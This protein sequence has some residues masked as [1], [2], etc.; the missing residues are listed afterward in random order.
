M[1][2]NYIGFVPGFYTICILITVYLMLPMFRG[3]EKVFRTILVPIFGL[4]EMLVRKDVDQVR[5]QALLDI[6]PERREEVMKAIAESFAK[7]ATEEPVDKTPVSPDGYSQ[8]V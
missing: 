1:K 3:S 8:I 6:P 4:E 5:K 7:S 2:K